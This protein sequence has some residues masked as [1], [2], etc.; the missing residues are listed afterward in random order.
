MEPRFGHDF[1][2]VRIHTDARASQSAQ[3]VNALAYTVGP[4]IVF[5]AGQY[6][7]GAPSGQRLLA[8]ELTHV[9]QQGAQMSIPSALRI[10]PEH[11]VGEDEAEHA[12][13][14]S[15]SSYP[16]GLR[17]NAAIAPAPLRR[18]AIYTGRILNE[19]SCGD[20]V[21]G[22]KW[23]CCDPN[24]VE[25]KGKKKDIDGKACPNEKFAPIFTCDNY[26]TTS[27]TRGCSDTDNWMALPKSRF[28][29]GKCAQ[30]L[31]ICANGKSTHAYVRD[32]SEREAWEV[33]LA[34]PAA[35]GVPPDFSGVIYGGDTDPDFKNDKRCHAAVQ[36]PTPPS[37]SGASP[38]GGK[39][40][41]GPQ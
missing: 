39:T 10:G 20:L 41:N 34:I 12:A 35:L 40:E 15:L 19:G 26:C 25:R 33:S 31:T 32:K 23:V 11:D 8:H 5:G 18:S 22:S 13:A 30:D 2:K 3:A 9:V 7:P 16:V 24:G 37:P 29:K 27:L 38:G 17:A 36:T 4:Q 1:G 6:Q 14:M 21:A 28:A